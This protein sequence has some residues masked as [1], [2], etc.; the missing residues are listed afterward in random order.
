M[1]IV[2]ILQGSLSLVYVLISFIIGFTIISK[3]SKYKNRL[4]VLV[5]MCWVMLSTLWLPEA[6]SFLM[7]LLGFG[8]LDIGWYFIIGNAF[9]PVALFC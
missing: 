5:G 7:S 8:T 9:V 1:D 6:A 3:Y 4:Y 2:D